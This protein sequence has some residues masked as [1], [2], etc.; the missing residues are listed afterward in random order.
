MVPRK[1][2]MPIDP[3]TEF[4]RELEVFGNEVEEAIQCFYNLNPLTR[5]IR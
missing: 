2:V 3:E 4:Q 1:G 5:P